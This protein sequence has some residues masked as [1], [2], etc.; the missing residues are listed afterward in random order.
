MYKKQEGDEL[1]DEDESI[2]GIFKGFAREKIE[3]I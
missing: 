2:Q 3:Q 1:I